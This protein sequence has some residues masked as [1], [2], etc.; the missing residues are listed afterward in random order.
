MPATLTIKKSRSGA[1]AIDYSSARNNH[2]KAH[3]GYDMKRVLAASGVNCT[4]K[5]G[6]AKMQAIW[7]KKKTKQ[8][9]MIEAYTIVQSFD[10]E[11]FDYRNENDVKLVNKMGQE[12]VKN[13]VPSRLALVYTQADGT[14]HVLHNHIIICNQDNLANNPN[15]IIVTTMATNDITKL[16]ISFG[17]KILAYVLGVVLK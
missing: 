14:H 5:D 16:N 13:V 17:N 2:D 9:R 3:N 4:P 1:K 7:R 12:L 6:K 11:N 15:I 8:K 10:P